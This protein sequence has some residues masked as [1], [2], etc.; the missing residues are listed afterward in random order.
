M[1]LNLV[2]NAIKYN[3]PEGKVHVDCEVRDDWV[4]INVRD[5]GV[6]LDEVQLGSLFEAFNRLGQDT[7]SEEGSGIGLVVTKRLVELMG[8]RIG[9]TSQVGVGSV[10]YVELPTSPPVQAPEIK[11]FEGADNAWPLAPVNA[12]DQLRLLQTGLANEFATILCVD[13][14][15]ASLRLLQQ[16]LATLPNVHL[17]TASNGRLGADPRT[18]A[19][20]V[21]AV[22]A[23]A[24]PGEAAAGIEAGFF[25]YLAKPFDVVDLLQAVG[26]GLAQARAQA[27]R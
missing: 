2:S 3:R 27:S 12:A 10:F 19:I 15:T 14:D 17:L 5:T 7:S 13:D 8:G 16:V 1:V 21:I 26:D 24:M 23:N 11:D 20:P 6:G 9:V 25:R 4:R 18:A 22:S